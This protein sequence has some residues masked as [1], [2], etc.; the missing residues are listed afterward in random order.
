MSDSL[1]P[2][3]Y[4]FMPG[5]PNNSPQ[6]YMNIGFVSSPYPGKTGQGDYGPLQG[7]GVYYRPDNPVYPYPMDFDKN[8]NGPELNYAQDIPR[9]IRRE[10]QAEIRAGVFGRKA[11]AESRCMSCSK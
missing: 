10:D 4:D 1:G 2:R 5:Y 7:G 6:K 8:G 11:Q 9:F 3:P